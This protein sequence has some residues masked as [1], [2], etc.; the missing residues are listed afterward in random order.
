MITRERT[1]IGLLI[2]YLNLQGISQDLTGILY[3]EYHFHCEIEG[4]SLSES[5]DR[6][7]S[8]GGLREE[9]V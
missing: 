2:F 9:K 7:G 6:G 4:K 1:Q 5:E 8:G 3:N